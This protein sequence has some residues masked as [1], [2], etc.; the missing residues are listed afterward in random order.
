MQQISTRFLTASLENA[1][2][3]VDLCFMASLKAIIKSDDAP[4]LRRN[5]G[6]SPYQTLDIL[7]LDPGERIFLKGDSL[8]LEGK[9]S[10]ATSRY[11]EAIRTSGKDISPFRLQNLASSLMEFY[12]CRTPDV[13]SSD[14][15]SASGA[16]ICGDLYLERFK[17]CPLFCPSCRGMFVDPVTDFCGHTYCRLC[18]EES[19]FCILCS[20]EGKFLATFGKIEQ[21]KVNIVLN[22]IMEAFADVDR[23]MK[24][25]REAYRLYRTGMYEEAVTSMNEALTRGLFP[26]IY[27]ML[28][29]CKCYLSMKRPEDAMGDVDAVLKYTNN[30]PQAHLLKAQVTKSLD[31]AE[32][33]FSS[34]I[35][36]FKLCMQ[37][38]QQSKVK[39]SFEEVVRDL[40]QPRNS[41][42]G[43]K[44]PLPWPSDS[45]SSSS[46]PETSPSSESNP[47]SDRDD[48]TGPEETSSSD[49]FHPED[50]VVADPVGEE[51][52]VPELPDDLN[53][54]EPHKSSSRGNC[55]PPRD[56]FKAG[57]KECRP[58][59]SQRSHAAPA[60]YPLSCISASA[61]SALPSN[62]N[63]LDNPPRP[64]ISLYDPEEFILKIACLI[65]ADD[66]E[67]PLCFKTFLEP[68]TTPCGHTFCLDCMFRSFDHKSSCPL[69]KENLHPYLASRS[70]MSTE[71]LVWLLEN[72]FK[73]EMES[74]RVSELAE[75]T[76]LD[77]LSRGENVPIFICT[78]AFPSINCPLHVFEPRY[79]LM[80][81]RCLDSDTKQFGMCAVPA[82]ASYHEYVNFGTMLEIISIKYSHDGRSVLHTVGRRRFRVLDRTMKDGYYESKVEYIVDLPIPDR[83][84]EAVTDLMKLV[85]L[86]CQTWFKSLHDERMKR[87]LLHYGPFPTLESHEPS[88]PAAPIETPQNGCPF[89]EP[90]KDKL[91]KYLKESFLRARGLGEVE[92]EPAPPK[93]FPPDGPTW[94]WYMTAILPVRESVKVALLSS[95]SVKGRLKYLNNIITV[96]LRNTSWR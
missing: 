46:D 48:P 83:E 67:C 74:R 30:S 18:V 93:Y 26:D 22:K 94:M 64:P 63:V 90:D 7:K 69:C 66:L 1:V 82:N 40:I 85:Y 73:E 3:E 29:R 32:D 65:T 54:P 75:M 79:K 59:F 96:A 72:F 56:L 70:R 68:V 11:I 41:V 24:L 80:I 60:P 17:D 36:Y 95:T 57:G 62:E 58:R 71:P 78:V 37:A 25:K 6:T 88:V 81:R 55:H 77:C 31:R 44:F 86:K 2:G 39:K 61:A 45:M 84:L 28:L 20:H 91:T 33:S 76:T 19:E 4:T 10:E 43:P 87:I 8:L 27:L 49:A 42:G 21:L 23:L 47:A 14:G 16:S 53:L 92:P 5:E 51:K 50:G 35:K 15:A 89:Y 12:L 13:G 38:T 9:L 34:Y 52:P